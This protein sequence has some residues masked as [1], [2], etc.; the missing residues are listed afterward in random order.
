M[1]IY[2]INEDFDFSKLTLGQPSTIQG[3][4][5]FTKIKYINNP[6]Y[7]ETPPCCTKQGFIKSGK[8]MYCD[9]MFE[10]PNLDFINWLEKLEGK[11]HELIYNNS[12]NWFENSLDLDDIESTFTSPIKIFKSGK[13]YLIRCNIKLPIIK[14]YNENEENVPLEDIKSDTQI[15][16][17]LA[18]QGIKFT[19]RNFQFEFEIKQSMIVSNDDIFDTCLIS[20]HNPLIQKNKDMK[21]P[22]EHTSS[23][24]STS[25]TLS[26]NNINLNDLGNA[27]IEDSLINQEKLNTETF[28]N[29][30]LE[31]NIE[32]SIIKNDIKEENII[33]D[34]LDDSTSKLDLEL[35]VNLDLDNKD[36][37]ITE[38][39]DNVIT[40]IEDIQTSK[41][42]EENEDE[43]SANKETID[44]LII[45]ESVI[46]TNN[47]ITNNINQYD[48][49]TENTENNEN[50]EL[51][52]VD[53][54][55]INNTN[56][57]TE[58]NLDSFNNNTLG[59]IN[60]RKPNQIYYEIYLE[61]RK[62]AKQAKQE[63]LKAYLKAKEIKETYMLESLVDDSDDSDFDII[64]KD[65][66]DNLENET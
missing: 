61:A 22:T 43:I 49:N 32:N 44:N 2:Q 21:L 6:L 23:T 33:K 35:D 59:S 41:S 19:N 17:I 48:E 26:T 56:D 53:T 25:S 24:S 42:I 47:E 8:K 39:D 13:Y 51:I 65:S 31:E 40:T 38:K 9:L 5:Y 34:T 12:K 3:G 36:N 30:S 64:S 66:E 4:A 16:S 1:S 57:L 15:I 45:D 60:L 46:D 54:D 62:K 50:E 20:K 18:I 28:S 52:E 14:V 58:V 55:L 29:K 37:I 11:C 27:I 10:R 63:A 7:I